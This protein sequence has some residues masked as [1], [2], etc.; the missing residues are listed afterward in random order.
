VALVGHSG[1][2]KSTLINALAPG[3]QQRTGDMSRYGTGRQTTTSARWL[4][5]AAGGTL[6]DTPGIRNLSVRGF[7]RT[8]LPAIF[9]EFPAEWLEDP[10]ALD[11]EDEELGLDFPERLQSLQRLWLEMD[12]RNPNQNVFR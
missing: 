1:V 11:P 5:C 2:G 12:E 4:P 3:L 8:L 10:M 7:P 6:I 9:P